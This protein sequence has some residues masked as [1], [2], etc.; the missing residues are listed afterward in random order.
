MQLHWIKCIGDK[1]CLLAEFNPSV[2]TEKG[3]YII[4]HGGQPSRAV[5]VGQ[6]NVADRI[7]AH[8]LNWEIVKHEQNGTLFVTWA[9]VSVDK[10]DGV[11]RY[12]ADRFRPLEGEDHPEVEHIVVNSPWGLVCR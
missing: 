9:Q 4:W 7:T 1:W 8:R 2:V 5:Y 3:V 12:L 11:E 10:R 6:G